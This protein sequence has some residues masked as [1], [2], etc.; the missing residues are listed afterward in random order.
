MVRCPC[1]NAQLTSRGA[2]RFFCVSC[3]NAVNGG[4]W[5][6]VSWRRDAEAGEAVLLCRPFFTQRNWLAGETVADLVEQNRENRHPVPPG[7]V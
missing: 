4:Q 1:K 3:L 6:R 5:V 7:V 2:K